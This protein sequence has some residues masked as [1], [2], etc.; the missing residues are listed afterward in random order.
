M[1]VLGLDTATAACSVA[2]WRGEA[3]IA[4]RSAAMARGHAEA[5]MPMVEAAMAEARVAY[6]DLDLIATTVGPGAFI[7]LRI[8]LAAAR[9]LALAAGVPIAGVSTLEAIAHGIRREVRGDRPVA[10]MLDARRGAVYLQVFGADLT[11]LDPPRALAL[12]AA[13]AALPTGPLVIAGDGAAAM[14][15]GMG[16][17]R[18]DLV[19]AES[20]PDAAIVAE[21][22]ARRFARPGTAL[23][24][25]PPSPLYL[26][27][28]GARLPAAGAAIHRVAGVSRR[29]A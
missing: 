23:P 3:L 7:G 28:S 22:C 26:G 6:G 9:G 29:G 4:H 8:G 16:P 20:R 18:G 14:V 15:A 27:P 13:F 21:M 1:K 25:R 24:R 2:V 10:A 5:L 19:V 17:G 11:P 12:A